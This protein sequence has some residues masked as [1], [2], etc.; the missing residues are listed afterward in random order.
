[1]HGHLI[2]IF[3]DSH[4]SNTADQW[5]LEAARNAG[6]EPVIAYADRLSITVSEAGISIYSEPMR[7]PSTGTVL[8]RCYRS[9]IARVLRS[10]GYKVVNTP[11]AMELCRDKFL[12]CN[13]LVQA[14]IPTVPTVLLP[15]GA[16]SAR[17]AQDF[18][19]PFI[20]KPNSASKGEGVMLL[21]RRNIIL[22]QGYIVQ[23]YV[24]TSAGRDIRVWVVGDQA[25]YAVERSN[26][27]SVVSNY[28]AG[29]TATAFTG[30]DLDKVNELA[31]AATHACGL[32]F[33]GVDIL[34]GSGGN[35]L[36]LEVN[37]NAGFRTLSLTGGPNILRILMEALAAQ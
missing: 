15:A 11:E 30:P 17:W 37:G 1:M 9:E 28:A 24:H 33:A 25:V 10:A 23:P 4:R 32:F 22:P 3:E 34:Y 12:T 29:G 21:N 6:F 8:M 20:A 35:Y 2:I 36:V 14:G 5:W 13:A 27:G 31:V 19:K 26:P 7:L 18:G 16:S